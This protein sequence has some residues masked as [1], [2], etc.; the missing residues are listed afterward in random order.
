MKFQ[1]HKSNSLYINCEFVYS[2]IKCQFVYFNIIHFSETTMPYVT[3]Q[4][5]RRLNQL[6][7][8]AMSERPPHD[9]DDDSLP[10]PELTEVQVCSC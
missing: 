6:T 3:R 7:K 2:Y 8:K 5:V 9:S 1:I 4:R 10:D